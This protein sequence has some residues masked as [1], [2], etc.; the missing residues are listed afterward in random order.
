M[1]LLRLINVVSGRILLDDTDL[2]TI[3]G[4]TVRER[5]ICLTQDPFLFPASVRSN[6]DPQAKSS[7]EAMVVALQKVG[8]WDVLRSK[9]PGP[10]SSTLDVLNMLMDGDILSHGQK[11]LFCLARAMLKTGSVL[12]LDEPTSSVDQQTD[13]RMQDLIRTEFEN[14]T[15]IMIAH[16]LASLFDFDRVAVLDGGRLVEFGAPA[17]LLKDEASHFAKLYF[18]SMS[19]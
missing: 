7:D 5:L 1:A 10:N 17:E 13:L 3:P 2:A 9:S 4:P 8:L 11:Q 6:L 19:A 14:H 15:I 12:I 18:S 16:R